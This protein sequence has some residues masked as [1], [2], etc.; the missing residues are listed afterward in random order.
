[1]K[2]NISVVIANQ[3]KKLEGEGMRKR[4]ESKVSYSGFF[5]GFRDFHKN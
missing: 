5:F 1:M 2:E 4:V 3:L